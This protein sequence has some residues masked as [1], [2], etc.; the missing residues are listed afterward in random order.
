LSGEIGASEHA[1]SEATASA[2]N[3]A[4]TKRAIYLP[5]DWVYYAEQPAA[6]VLA[7]RLSRAMR[8]G[9]KDKFNQILKRLFRV[10]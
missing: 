2:A 5:P 10:L 1:A 7:R 4:D 6:V 3:P 8:A 9:D